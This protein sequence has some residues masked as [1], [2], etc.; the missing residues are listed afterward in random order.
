MAETQTPNYKWVKPDIG[1]DASTWGNVLNTTFDAI[2][3]VVYANQQAGVPIGTIMM[4]GGSA[5]PVNWLW[6]D[7]AVYLDT[8]V[9]AL[10]PVLGH[11]FVGSDA[12]HTAV[13]NLSGGR[14]PVGANSWAMGATGG[15]YNHTLLSTEMPIHAHAGS[16]AAHTHSAYQDVHNHAASQDAH[17]HGVANGTHSHNIHTNG[18]SHN[19][20]TG[21]HSHGNVMQA[22]TG[23]FSL[24]ATGALHTAGRT[25]TAGDLGGYTDQVGDLGGYADAQYSNIGNTD[26]RQPGVYTDNRQPGVHVDTQTPAIAI[27]NAGS[28]VTHNNMPPYTVVG[29]IIRFK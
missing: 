22:N 29:F 28:G 25:D 5:P 13:P 21:S 20:H 16:Q 23:Y 17:L 1:G 11:V 10:A 9:P 8:D 19:I 15:E 6:C 2:D 24:A 14:G 27:G 4:F 26:T 18:H 3:S 12:S 7:G